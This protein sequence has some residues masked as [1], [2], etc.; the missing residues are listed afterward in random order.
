MDPLNDSLFGAQSLES[1]A[2]LASALAPP[3][4]PGHFDELRGA[5]TPAALALPAAPESPAPATATPELTPPWARFFEHLGSGGFT[6]LPRRAINLERQIRDNG[7]TYNVY[8]DA[9]GPQRPW[10]LDLFPLI[11]SPESWTQIEAGVLQRV[12]VLDR[13]MADVYGP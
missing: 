11:V 13:V 5:A 8:A 12:R 4:A 9:D 1:P 6:D 10:S 2:A 3:A 7:V